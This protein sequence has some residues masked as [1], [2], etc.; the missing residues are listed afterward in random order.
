V[1]ARALDQGMNV[2]EI[3]GL[4]AIDP[5]FLYKLERIHKIDQVLR[6]NSL[7]SLTPTVM[8]QAKKSGFSDVQIAERLMDLPW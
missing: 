5:W 7:L 8:L 3:N 4:T 1:L 6:S 2:E